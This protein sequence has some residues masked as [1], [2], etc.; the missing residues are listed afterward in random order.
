MTSLKPRFNQ[1]EVVNRILRK[2]WIKAIECNPDSYQA[3]LYRPVDAEIEQIDTGYEEALFNQLD[4]NQK[5]LD[6]ADPIVVSVL[7]NPDDIQPVVTE[8]GDS[9]TPSFEQP[10]VLRIAAETV[11]IGSILEWEEVITPTKTK[12]V[13]WYVHSAI[14]L[15]TTLA[16]VLYNVIPCR[17]FEGI[18]H[19]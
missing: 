17:D 3:L 19:G 10:M 15:G 12:R 16:G 7:D 2:D 1:N 4:E 6:Y 9:T 8:S 18:K 5:A 13:W 14:S 11:P